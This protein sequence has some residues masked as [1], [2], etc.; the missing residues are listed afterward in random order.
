MVHHSMTHLSEEQLKCITVKQNCSHRDNLFSFRHIIFFLFLKNEMLVLYL[1][2]WRLFWSSWCIHFRAGIS[3]LRFQIASC[4]LWSTWSGPLN[5]SA[6]IFFSHYHVSGSELRDSRPRT[7][8]RIQN[9]VLIHFVRLVRALM[10]LW[11]LSKLS[12]RLAT[13]RKRCSFWMLAETV[14]TRQPPC[15]GLKSSAKTTRTSPAH[16]P[17]TI[18]F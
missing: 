8:K 11:L 7:V 17:M 12:F 15:E 1:R 13:E 14:S 18:R 2:F 6:L 5:L 4:R 10:M 16:R 3:N 9:S